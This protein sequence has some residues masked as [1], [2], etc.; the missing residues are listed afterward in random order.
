MSQLRG[1]EPILGINRFRRSQFLCNGKSR[2][3]NLDLLGSRATCPCRNRRLRLIWEIATHDFKGYETLAYAN[4]EGRTPMDFGPPLLCLRT[5]PHATSP[6]SNGHRDFANP[7]RESW[8]LILLLDALFR[9]IVF[10]SSNLSWVYS[11]C[12]HDGTIPP[13]LD[14]SY[15]FRYFSH[16]SLNQ[17]STTL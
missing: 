6:R 8:P 15:S 3:P 16:A 14:P 17:P 1:N 10:P 9:F 5:N 7:S 13:E 11:H 4:A 2:M 12:I